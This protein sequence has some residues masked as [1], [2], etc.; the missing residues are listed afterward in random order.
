MDDILIA[1]RLS[2]ATGVPCMLTAEQVGVLLSHIQRKEDDLTVLTY[3][4]NHER[5]RANS[6]A[7]E[8]DKLR[9]IIAGLEWMEEL[10]RHDG[11]GKMVK[12]CAYCGTCPETG[13][14]ADC[15]MGEAIAA[16][17]GGE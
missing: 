4:Y 9:A 17:K 2:V 13:H 8:I 7:A 14:D 15:K 1:L 16:L 10:D 3:G 12:F 5:A 6:Q 11:S